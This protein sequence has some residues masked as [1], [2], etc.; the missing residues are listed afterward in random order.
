[1]TQESRSRFNP[2]LLSTES[3]SAFR[4]PSKSVPPLF[5]SLP[6]L[7]LLLL[8]STQSSHPKAMHISWTKRR[9]CTS[10]QR[11]RAT[12]GRKSKPHARY[13]R[14]SEFMQG[15]RQEGS[16]TIHRSTCFLPRRRIRPWLLPL[17]AYSSAVCSFLFELDRPSLLMTTIPTPIVSTSGASVAGSHSPSA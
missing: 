3:A 10:K 2:H 5:V 14:C 7:R 15:A 13:L 12:G 9:V 4:P 1:M 11:C 16:K 17:L 8:T 6:I